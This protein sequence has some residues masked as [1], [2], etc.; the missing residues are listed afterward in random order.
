ML[1]VP[2][3]LALLSGCL[4]SD[5][6]LTGPEVVAIFNFN[7]DLAGFEGSIS[8]YGL[9]ERDS[10]D[11]DF[12]NVALPTD[13][14]QR[15]LGLRF[16]DVNTEVFA[17]T[18]FPITL[19]EANT[20]YD[21][22]FLINLEVE[23]L[24]TTGDFD[25]GPN[26]VIHLKAG[27]VN[28]EPQDLV[29]NDFVQ[30][31]IDKGFAAQSGADLLLFGSLVMPESQTSTGRFTIGNGGVPVSV[32]SDADGTIWIVFGVDSQAGHRVGVYIDDMTIEFDQEG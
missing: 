3:A 29:N 32:Q 28:A 19:P 5:E 7:N 8:D 17:Y 31:D 9:D 4:N 10:I 22:T 23:N 11:F 27:G 24:D 15:G 18:Y 25:G 14:T 13:T 12:S 2:A 20:F 30:V 6:P 26:E 21:L 1:L 16:T